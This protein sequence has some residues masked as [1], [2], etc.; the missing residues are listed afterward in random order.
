MD[1]SASLDAVAGKFELRLCSETVSEKGVAR[2]IPSRKS[3]SMQSRRHSDFR[4][5]VESIG[6][7]PAQFIYC[8][9]S[10]KMRTQIASKNWLF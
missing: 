9:G 10:D 2:C 8:A 3:H 6:P 1:R 7:A 4:T 5:S